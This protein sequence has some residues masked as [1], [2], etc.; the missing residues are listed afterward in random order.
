MNPLRPAYTAIL[1]VVILVQGFLSGAQAQ[2]DKDVRALN[3]GK[4]IEREIA[5]ARRTPTSFRSQR[6]ST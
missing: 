1:M 4:A 3:P 5:G 6:G 2:G